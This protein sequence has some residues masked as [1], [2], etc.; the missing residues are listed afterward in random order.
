MSPEAAKLFEKLV[1]EMIDDGFERISEFSFYKRMEN[2]TISL[3]DNAVSIAYKGKSYGLIPE[4]E[5]LKLN[6]SIY[7]LLTSVRTVLVFS[8]QRE[9][10]RMMDYL[11]IFFPN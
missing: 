1:Q 4:K 8:L 10:G 2:I 5:F 11:H 6:D 3:I 9:M 7:P